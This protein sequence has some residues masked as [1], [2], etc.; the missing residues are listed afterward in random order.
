MTRDRSAAA[1]ALV[2]EVEDS[3]AGIAV[4]DRERVFAPF[5][6]AATAQQANPGGA[7]LGLAIVRDIALLHGAALALEDGGAGRGLKVTVRF[8]CL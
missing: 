1:A 8:P 2:V 4:A 3:G 7:G 5:Y 6:R